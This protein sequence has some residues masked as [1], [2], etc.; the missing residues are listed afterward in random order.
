MARLP[1][2]PLMTTIRCPDPISICRCLALLVPH[3]T[4]LSIGIGRQA[5][6][7]VVRRATNHTSSRASPRNYAVRS[8]PQ[9]TTSQGSRRLTTFRALIF[10]PNAT[11]I[12]APR[13]PFP[14]PRRVN[15]HSTTSC[16]VPSASWIP[17]LPNT[18]PVPTRSS[19]PTSASVATCRRPPTRS[20]SAGLHRSH[21]C[22]GQLSAL[23][24]LPR[25]CRQCQ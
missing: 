13:G 16:W 10:A 3:A 6:T 24:Q 7:P 14:A 8:I 20:G 22:H 17:G 15:C 4:P 2:M 5:G 25:Q 18:T 9:M 1:T 19:L 11:T 12:T 23:C 21:L